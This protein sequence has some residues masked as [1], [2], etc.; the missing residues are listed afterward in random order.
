MLTV[1]FLVLITLAAV[2]ANKMIVDRDQAYYEHEAYQQAAILA[3]ALLQEIDTKEFDE[4]LLESSSGWPAVTTFS[5]DMTSSYTG[6]VNPGGLPDT[7]TPYRSMSTTYFND[8]DDYNGYYRKTASGG[9]TDFRLTVVVSY[10]NGTDLETLTSSRTYYKKIIV[11]VKNP[12]YFRKKDTNG[13]G[14]E[15]DV[16]LKFSMVKA[17]GWE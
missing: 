9:L 5:T 4:N 13:D 11:T 16:A 6:T 10:V 14:V 2:N 15:E 17:Y 12:T 1:A 8:V 3:N 7:V